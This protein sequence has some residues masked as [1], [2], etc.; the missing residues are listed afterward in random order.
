MKKPLCLLLAALLLAAPFTTAAGV[1][2]VVSSGSGYT[3]GGAQ[4]A[5]SEIVPTADVANNGWALST[6][7]D[8]YA[9]L[10]DARASEDTD[11]YVTQLDDTAGETATITHPAPGGCDVDS[12]TVYVHGGGLGGAV[13]LAVEISDDGVGWETAVEH[14]IPT[15]SNEVTFSFTALGYS[16]PALIYV[17]FA[18]GGDSTYDTLVVDNVVVGVNP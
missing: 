18:P 7:S 5:P 3:D 10:D 6:G 16:D 2:H 14:S 12:V 1:M 11:S 8:V 4:C 17:R 9:L 13:N 15:G